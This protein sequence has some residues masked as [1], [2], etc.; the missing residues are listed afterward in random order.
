MSQ[1]M[2]IK[3]FYDL[4]DAEDYFNFF[5]IE[6]D[7]QLI[8]VKR[9]HILKEYGDLINSGFEKFE[10]NAVK[11]FDFL[12]FSLLKVYGDFE[13][14]YAPSAADIWKMY[15]KNKL[16]GCYSCSGSIGNSCVQ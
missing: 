8:N 13:N 12:R 6:Y 11:L 4:I 15:K 16:N 7:Q 5:N 9:F 14:G 10:N 1:Q 2:S 3:N